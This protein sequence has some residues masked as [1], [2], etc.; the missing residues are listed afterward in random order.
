MRTALLFSFFSIVSFSATAN[1]QDQTLLEMPDLG[2]AMSHPKNWQVTPV[3]KSPDMKVLIPIE[4]SSQRA[5]LELYNVSFS[6]EKDV[7]QLGQKAINERMRR[8][9]MRQ[10]EE[11]L[12]GV[13]MLLTKVSFSDKEGQQILMT[14]L[15]YSRTAKKLMFRLS[16]APD[17]F[18]KAEFAWRQTMNTFRTGRAWLPEDPTKKPDPKDP[19]RTQ[20][21]T[22]VVTNPNSLDGQNKTT[23]PPVSIEATI[24][25]RKVEIRIPGEWAG[26]V[27]EDG[28]ILLTNPDVG[29]QVRLTLASALD[30]DPPQRALL[31]ASSKT[32]G[33]FQKVNKRDESVPEK[34]RAGAS[35]AAVWRSGTTAQGDLFSCDG[36]CFN[37]DFYFVVSYRSTNAS[38]IGGE[39]KAIEN[40]LQNSTIQIL[41]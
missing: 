7:W 31:A 9:L 28:A 17:D 11:E 3:K 2:L 26:K 6:S 14:G 34:N 1:A 4:G 20:L 32:L 13:P 24:S 21:P 23:K 10:W 12:L 41:P 18:D 8:E 25:G 36:V 27:G 5:T 38:K 15:V 29:S 39:R 30:S 35:A 37:G 40:L 22:P 19:Q 16:A 33:D